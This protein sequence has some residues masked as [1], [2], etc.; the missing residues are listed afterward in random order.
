VQVRQT[1]LDGGK[2]S[3]HVSMT[4]EGPGEDQRPGHGTVAHNA[5]L[6]ARVSPAGPGTRR[7]IKM[8]ATAVDVDRAARRRA[9]YAANVAAATAGR[10]ADGQDATLKRVT[11]FIKRLKETS[12]RQRDALVRELAPLRLGRFLDEG[13]PS[14]L[15]RRSCAT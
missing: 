1:A 5:F 6:R 3:R 8:A 7:Q 10:A 12:E 9:L 11:A 13:L 4:K 14:L 15:C 2:G